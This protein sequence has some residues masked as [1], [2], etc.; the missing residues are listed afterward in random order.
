MPARD[1]FAAGCARYRRTCRDISLPVI[2][3]TPESHVERGA[4]NDI[5]YFIEFRSKTGALK[6]WLQDMVPWCKLM[7]AVETECTSPNPLPVP[8][9]VDLEKSLLIAAMVVEYDEF[10]FH[11]YMPTDKNILRCPNGSTVPSD[12]DLAAVSAGQFYKMAFWTR[13]GLLCIRHGPRGF[14]FDLIP[15]IPSEAEEYPPRRIT[16]PGR[17]RRHSLCGYLGEKCR[18][19]VIQERRLAGWE[20]TG[21]QGDVIVQGQDSNIDINLPD[22]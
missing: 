16:S 11:S 5:T 13:H 20:G 6:A 4:F 10:E 8:R 15:A 1:Y 22:Y 7:L 19:K 18:G 12:N 3:S 17:P 21:V 2:D 9:V 14:Y